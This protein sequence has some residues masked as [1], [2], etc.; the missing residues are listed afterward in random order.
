MEQTVHRQK[1]A[2]IELIISCRNLPKVAMFSE[3]NPLAV[4]YIEQGSAL[5]AQ[6]MS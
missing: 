5:R 1:V 2:T 3:A 4:L 6:K